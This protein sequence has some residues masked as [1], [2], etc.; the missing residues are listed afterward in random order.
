MLCS[1]EE[2][3]R[4]FAVDQ[5]L[6]IRG[7]QELGDDSMR[8]R[9]LPYLN[10]LATSLN[11]L[12]SWEESTEP[13][14]TC[15]FTKKELERLREVPLEVDYFPCHTQALERAVKVCCLICFCLCSFS[16]YFFSFS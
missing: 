16:N 4:S 5:I 1:Q 3:E 2:E 13:V 7:E 14:I 15:K 12:I 11:G 6:S 9:V 8:L 10:T